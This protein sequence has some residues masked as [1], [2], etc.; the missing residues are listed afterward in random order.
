[1]KRFFTY[2]AQCHCVS[3]VFMFLL[4]LLPNVAA[5]QSSKLIEIDASNFAPVQT[6]AISGVAI[7]AIERDPS[8]R[9]CARIKMHINRMTRE[10][11]REL[12]V[13]VIGGNVVVTKQ[14]V[15]QEGNG[16]IIELTAKPQTRF[17]LHHDKYGDSNEVS[18]DL[19]GD[20]EYKIEAMLNSLHSVVVN[21]N[22][23]GADVYL[24]NSYKGQIGSNYSLTIGEVVPGVHKIKIQ[25]GIV[26]SEKEIEVS[27]GNIFFRIDLNYES[28]RPQYVVFIVEP[29]IANVTIDGKSYTL[30]AQGVA[31]ATLKNG[32][33]TYSVSAKDYHEEQGTFTVNGAKVTKNIKLQPAFGWLNISSNESLEGANIYIDNS[34]VG[35]VPINN[36]KL[37]SGTHRIR[38]TKDLYKDFDGEITIKDNETLTY[39]Q[40]LKPDFANVNISTKDG[41]GIYINNEYKGASSWSGKLATG[42][43]IFEARKDGHRPT[44]MSKDITATP[45]T[46]SY[47]IAAPTPIIGTVDIK[48]NPTLA[49]IYIDGNK[50]NDQT[51]TMV[52]LIVGEHTVTL[53]KNGYG[54]YT[55]NIVIEEGKILNVEAILTTSSYSNYEDYTN[56]SDANRTEQQASDSS[57][58]NSTNYK[59]HNRRPSPNVSSGYRALFDLSYMHGLGN[60]YSNIGVNFVLGHQF[61]N[62]IYLGAGFGVNFNIKAGTEYLPEDG[63]GYAGKYLNP[64]RA[65]VPLYAYLRTYLCDT[66]VSPFFAVAAGG[67]FSAKQEIYLPAYDKYSTISAFVNPQFGV[68]F[69]RSNDTSV[70]LAIGYQL[71]SAPYCIKHEYHYAMLNYKAAY[72]IDLH[73]GFTF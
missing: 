1:M 64:C 72:G 5:A 17:Y 45:S 33:Y 69:R 36:H 59:K 14:I 44:V 7:D 25:H 18:L 10:E 49:D 35:K 26:S 66:Y 65:F 3:I 50:I 40:E 43:Y 24:D 41:C 60:P 15:V 71:F 11:I 55:Q 6:D 53:R 58:S 38:I 21:S 12:S 63:L 20:T 13:R 57:Y 22:T 27:S 16:L 47:T 31:Q 46:Q 32:S 62:Y 56:D 34:L 54:N 28:A 19:V 73:F 52:D 70:Y 51:P 37:P 42:T 8:M 48:S 68:D 39:R 30:D 67:N 9:P 61:N 4:A 2:I 29:N 23:I